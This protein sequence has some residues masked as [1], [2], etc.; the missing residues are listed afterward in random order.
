[1]SIETDQKSVHGAANQSPWLFLIIGLGA[2]AIGTAE[3]AAMSLVP[4][5][6]HRFALSVPQAGWTVVFYAL[7]VCIGAPIIALVSAGRAHRSTLIATMLLYTLGNALSAAAP[8]AICLFLFRFMTGLP[9]GAYFST[10]SLVAASL[11]APEKR[12]SAVGKVFLGLTNATIV[13]VPLA[14]LLSQIS[15][16]RIV[17][18]LIAT[19]SCLTTCLLWRFIPHNAELPQTSLR[20]EVRA[21][22]NTRVCLIL[23]I[24]GIGFGSLFCVYTYLASIMTAVT[25]A[26]PSFTPL[27]LAIFGIGLTIGTS[28]CSHLA[29]RKMSTTLGGVL[30]LGAVSTA[31]FPLAS[32]SLIPLG[33]DIFF[34]GASGGLSAVVSAYLL[35]VAREGKNLAVAL[36]H[37]AFNIANALGPWLGG[38]AITVGMGWTSVGWVGCALSLTALC[39]FLFEFSRYNHSNP[40]VE[41]EPNQKG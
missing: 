22:R 16:W 7:G 26:N 5:V 8:N 3:F 35:S 13:G 9:H 21:L 32:R 19:L 2:F 6:A 23:A 33:I 39:M 40:C 38:L 24:G 29:D 28:I 18:G 10:A 41:M 11:V 27:I 17:F 4:L 31:L 12:A 34:I 30:I 15:G 14:N 36:S 37:S 20:E 1:M 25:H